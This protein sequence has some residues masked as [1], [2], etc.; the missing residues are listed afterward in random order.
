MTYTPVAVNHLLNREIVSTISSL[1]RMSIIRQYSQFCRLT[2]GFFLQSQFLV[3][4]KYAALGKV[5][6]NGAPNGG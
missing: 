5:A 4:N 1:L 2:K 3:K 6:I